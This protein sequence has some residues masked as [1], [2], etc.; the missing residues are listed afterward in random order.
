MKNLVQERT[1]ELEQL[2]KDGRE[3][4]EKLEK[5]LAQLKDE[6]TDDQTIEAM[7]DEANKDG[8]NEL[9]QEEE[10]AQW[11]KDRE[12]S[13]ECPVKQ[14][15]NWREIIPFSLFSFLPHL[16]RFRAHVVSRSVPIPA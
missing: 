8:E 2:L 11:L 10:Y 15:R 3:K 13:L 7:V 9:R 6:Q 16:W 5:E 4:H 12:V 1:Q 14:I